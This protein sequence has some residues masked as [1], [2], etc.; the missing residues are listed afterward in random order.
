M[1]YRKAE[2]G[3]AHAKQLRGHTSEPQA[4]AP[5]TGVLEADDRISMLKDAKCQCHEIQIMRMVMYVVFLVRSIFALSTAGMLTPGRDG[6]PFFPQLG[7]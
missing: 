5:P 6:S 7:K 1:D 3:G 2:L 4:T